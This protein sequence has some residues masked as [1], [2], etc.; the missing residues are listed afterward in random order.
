MR[1]DDLLSKYGST[2]AICVALGRPRSTVYQWKYTGIPYW[3]QC[4]IEKLTGGELTADSPDADGD[5]NRPDE[6]SEVTG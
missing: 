4:E 5:G 6:R 3:R 2:A 1:F